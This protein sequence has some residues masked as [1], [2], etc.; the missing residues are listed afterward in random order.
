MNIPFVKYTTYGNNFIIV[1][2]TMQTFFPE[3]QLSGYATRVTNSAFGVGADSLIII[4]NC[5]KKVIERINQHKKYWSKIPDNINAE[6]IFRMF[7]P[8]G[9]E[10]LNCGNGLLALSNYFFINKEQSTVYIT[11][12]IPS[13]NPRVRSI[14]INNEKTIHWVNI[15]KLSKVKD[16]LAEPEIRQSITEHIDKIDNIKINFRFDDF[17]FLKLKTI[18]I[19]GYLLSTGEPHFVIFTDGMFQD[20]LT[21]ALIFSQPDSRRHIDMGLWLVDYIGTSLNKQYAHYFPEGINVNFV[22][23]MDSK[24]GIIKYRC[25]ERGINKETLACGTGATAVAALSS[26]LN[27][28]QCNRI[29]VLPFRCRCYTPDAEMIVEKE[30]EN[31][32]LYGYPNLICKGEL[33]L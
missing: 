19:S 12:E 18:H 22:K 10:A 20:P 25:F 1:D 17:Q 29:T 3:S 16:K 9:D 13:L 30:G 7:E 26:N 21:E 24:K 2:E 5:N 6:Y 31:Y 11:T 8:N 15:G 14:G 23:I 32:I 28:I 33:I 27:L 4:Q